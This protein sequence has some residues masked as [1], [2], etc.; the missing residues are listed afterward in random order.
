[1]QQPPVEELTARLE[2]VEPSGVTYLGSVLE[3]IIEPLIENIRG[4][5]TTALENPLLIS[6]ITDGE[7]R[8]SC[9]MIT[10]KVSFQKCLPGVVILLDSNVII[11]IGRR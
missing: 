1:M 11:L 3:D 2:E 8:S 7:V 5:D 6:I 9:I 4:G 10:A